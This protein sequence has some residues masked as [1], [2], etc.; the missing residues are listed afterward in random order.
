MKT[1]YKKLICLALA[2][3]MLLALCACR[4]GKPK[5]AAKSD[6]DYMAL[7]NKTHPLPDGW[8]ASLKTVSVTNSVGD[9]VEVEAAAFAAYE[10]LRADLENN[11]GIYLEL[12]SA[13]RSIADQQKTMDSFIEKYGADYA[14]KTVAQPGF[15]EHHTGLALDLYFKLKNADGTF[16]DV[17]Y[18][19]DIEKPEYSDIWKTIHSRLADYG[20]ILRY[21]PGKE[22]ITGYRSELWHIRYLDSV[23]TAKK[24]MSQ[25][26]LTLE[27]YLA[28]KTAPEVTIDLGT[29]KLYTEEELYNAM[30]A[31]KCQFASWGGC[32]LHSIQY[33]GDE[34]CTEENLEWLRSLGNGK[35]YRDVAAFL[36]DFHSPVEDGP[37]TWE[38]DTEYPDY[39]W[40]LAREDGKDFEIVSTGY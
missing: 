8:E 34:E 26:G 16:T 5:T 15:S 39:Q 13:R 23:E 27:E 22:H 28:G 14:M 2:A 24:I 37:Y 38:P 12:D 33:A 21:L 6:I 30:L 40:W 3:C 19:E 1:S 11:H 31:I 7:V 29:S 17:Y 36:M 10:K 9:T 4:F 25:T 18:N 32:E 35:D 20:F